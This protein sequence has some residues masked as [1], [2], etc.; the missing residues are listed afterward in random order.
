MNSTFLNLNAKDF[1]KGL[2]IAVITA[3]ITILY[4][5]VQT[6]S[7]T[8]DW[9]LISSTAITSALAYI[10]KN[11]FTNSNGTILKKESK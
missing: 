7:L 4:D 3:V 11:L 9:K 8:F 6:G 10:M 1:I 2:V 5:T